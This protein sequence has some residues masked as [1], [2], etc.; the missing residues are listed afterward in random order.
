MVSVD[1]SSL[2]PHVRGCPLDLNISYN[3]NN[4]TWT[5][6]IDSYNSVVKGVSRYLG[7]AILECLNEQAVAYDRAEMA[8]EARA[9]GG[10]AEE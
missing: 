8:A 9:W 2:E 1:F 10:Y 5:V 7:V 4:Y 6:K 3:K